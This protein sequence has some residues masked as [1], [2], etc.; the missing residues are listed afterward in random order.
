[1][2]DLRQWALFWCMTSEDSKYSKIQICQSSSRTLLERLQRSAIPLAGGEGASLPLFSPLPKNPT[3]ALCHSDFAFPVSSSSSVQSCQPYIPCTMTR[4][5]WRPLSSRT[6]RN[7]YD[8]AGALS[9]A[10]RRNGVTRYSLQCTHMQ[11][12]RHLYTGST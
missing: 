5:V 8:A 3:P 11:I 4:L 7:Q 1:M 10:Q 12:W 6:Q 2:L 9:C